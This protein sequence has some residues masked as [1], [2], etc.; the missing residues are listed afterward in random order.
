MKNLILQGISP[1]ELAKLIRLEI[2]KATTSQEPEELL[3]R[4]QTAKFLKID[5]ST[6]WSWTK[7]GRLKAYGIAGSKRYY[8]RSELMEAL[9]EL[10]K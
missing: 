10:K 3:T 4:E 2:E 5:L 7:K 8:K 9:T 6:L 1:E